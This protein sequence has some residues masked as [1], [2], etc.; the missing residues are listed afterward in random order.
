MRMWH[1][2]NEEFEEYVHNA[3][4]EIMSTFQ[5][6]QAAQALLD[7]EITAVKQAVDNLLGKVGTLSAEAQAQLDNEVGALKASSDRLNGVQTSATPAPAPTPT[8]PP[9]AATEAPVEG[10][11]AAEAPAE[12]PAP[13][14]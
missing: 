9:V 10:E 8:P 1:N 7:G 5:D 14:A 6:L 11:A 2:S 12:E 3:L 4:G 13:E